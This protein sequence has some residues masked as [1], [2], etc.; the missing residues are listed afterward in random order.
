MFTRLLVKLSTRKCRGCD[1]T[2]PHTHHLT[3]IGRR[4]YAH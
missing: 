3:W 4:R 2:S 1:N